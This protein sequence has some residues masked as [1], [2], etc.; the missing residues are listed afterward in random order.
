M[1]YLSITI[2]LLASVAWADDP[3]NDEF[4]GNSLSPSWATNGEG[5]ITVTGGN[6]QIVRSGTNVYVYQSGITG[7][8]SV[9]ARL[10][11]SHNTSSGNSDLPSANENITLIA[12][13]GDD[14]V[15]DNG[16]RVEIEQN[17]DSTAGKNEHNLL[18]YVND[19]GP[20]AKVVEMDAVTHW[21][22]RLNRVDDLFSAFYNAA[23]DCSGEWTEM[24]P[25]LGSL[26]QLDNAGSVSIGFRAQ[27]DATWTVDY[28]RCTGTCGSVSDGT[29]RTTANGSFSM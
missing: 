16:N 1:K 24:I 10:G 18:H 13:I 29:V 23:G 17:F 4:S 20:W 12:A 27:Y 25:T 11:G 7:D 8:F 2:I 26:Y 9:Y 6:L 15:S 5:T 19:T 22:Y 14:L 3:L 21:C 28:F